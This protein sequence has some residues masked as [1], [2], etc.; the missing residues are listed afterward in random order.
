MPET[1]SAR[2]PRAKAAPPAK[3]AV[4]PADLLRVVQWL[5]T[6]VLVER[7]VELRILNLGLLAG[8]NVHQIGAPGLAKSLGLREFAKCIAGARYFEK[9]LHAQTPADAVIGGYDMEKFANGGGLVRDVEHYAPNAHIIFLDELPRA[10]GPTLD[11]VLPLMNSEERRAE[12]NGGMMDCPTLLAVTASNSWFDADNTQAQALADRV[13]LMQLVRDLKSDESFKEVLRRHHTRRIAERD[14]TFTRETV[15]L[16]Q[17]IQAQS[18]VTH[19]RL[20]A[21][22]MDAFAKLRR[23]ANAA[24][25]PVSPRRWVEMGRVCRA[26]AWMSGR[27]ECIPDDLVVCEHGMWREQKDIPEAAKLVQDYHGRF[28]RAAREHRTEAAKPLARVEQIRPQVEGTPP[29]Q[30]LDPAVIKEAINASRAID[31]VKVRVEK[32]LDEAER[33]KRDAADLRDLDNELLAVQIWFHENSLPTR[34]KPAS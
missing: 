15:E 31:E 21:E 25:L 16:E 27:E 22:F 29:S 6:R 32:V 28:V 34:Y 30:E 24:G 19:V 2:K 9:T 12:H 5:D 33:E 17:V 26:N 23:D 18:E 3:V 14:G 20:G 11:S 8:V 4:E 1:A 13:T 10:N 7:A